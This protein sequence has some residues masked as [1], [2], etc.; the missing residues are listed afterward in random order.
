MKKLSLLSAVFAMAI[1]GGASAANITI[2]YSPTCPHC[3]NARDFIGSALVYEYP[4]LRVDAVNVMEPENMQEFRAAMEKCKSES[5]GVPLIVIGDECVHGYANVLD[6][7]IRKHV[8]VG[9][10]DSEKNAAADIRKEM[11]ADAQKVRDAN[12]DRANAI[13]ER[14]A[15]D[16]KKTDAGGGAIYFYAILLALVLGLGFVLIRKGKK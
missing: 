2:Y 10:S 14:S 11:T 15:N 4:S 7:E 6:D 16:Q 9:M 8:E 12:P 3:H 13:T 1:F 5:G